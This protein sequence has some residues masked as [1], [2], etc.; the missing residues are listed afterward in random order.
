MPES[1]F[2]VYCLWL[3]LLFIYL[4]HF[5]VHVRV[6]THT[7]TRTYIHT[8]AC[9]HTCTRTHAHVHMHACIYTHTCKHIIYTLLEQSEM[10]CVCVCVCTLLGESHFNAAQNPHLYFQVLL[11]SQQFESVRTSS[12]VCTQL[13]DSYIPYNGNHLRKK[14]SF[15]A[16]VREKTFMI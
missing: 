1:K 2:C 3:D 9:A 7:H 16:M 12:I 4:V 6:H 11:L 14:I 15:F 10:S 13:I 8:H 5:V